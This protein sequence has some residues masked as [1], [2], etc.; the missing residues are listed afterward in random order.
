[1][2]ITACLHAFPC[3]FSWES[4]FQPKTAFESSPRALS[5]AFKHH[6]LSAI[7]GAFQTKK[8]SSFQAPINNPSGWNPV[9][10]NGRWPG[11]ETGWP[12]VEQGPSPNLD[13]AK[14][15]VGHP[16]KDVKKSFGKNSNFSS[17]F[18]NVNTS[19]PTV[20]W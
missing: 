16:V 20:I 13:L 6:F 18:W 9:V 17:L 1:M 12:L 14:Y 15:S 5:V 19:N 2:V 10:C 7:M 4:L 8:T 3:C 11:G